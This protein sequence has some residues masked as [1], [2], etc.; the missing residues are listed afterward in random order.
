M[1]RCVYKSV[2]ILYIQYIRLDM[3]SYE[4]YPEKCG[5]AHLTASSSY[6]QPQVIEK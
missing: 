6:Y 4:P 3:M 1:Q 5:S 2:G